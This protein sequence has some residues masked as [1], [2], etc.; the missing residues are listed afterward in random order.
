M[1][2]R[3]S[4]SLFD[5]KELRP[6]GWA[7]YAILSYKILVSISLILTD[8]W[9]EVY[10]IKVYIDLIQ[11]QVLLN[12]L[13]TRQK[14]MKPASR[15]VRLSLQI[16]I[17]KALALHPISEALLP[18]ALPFSISDGCRRVQEWRLEESGLTLPRTNNDVSACR[19]NGI[20]SQLCCMCQIQL[21]QHTNGL[22]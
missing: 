8:L 5:V 21:V 20:A 6:H 4:F 3:E 15:R 13:E 14:R 19:N 2:M 1:C 18:L 11:R 10:S 22:K 7:L 17:L 9:K 16:N 12:T